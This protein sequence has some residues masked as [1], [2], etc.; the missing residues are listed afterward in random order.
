MPHR[1]P[2]SIFQ[3]QLAPLL[4]W[5]KRLDSLSHATCHQF[6]HLV[7]Y[8]CEPYVLVKVKDAFAQIFVLG[9]AN[10][11]RVNYASLG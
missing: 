9:A 4:L 3:V 1:S 5:L 10:G 8:P 7:N 6:S 11:Q 2:E